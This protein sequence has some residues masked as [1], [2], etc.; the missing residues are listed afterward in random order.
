MPP[1]T[2]PGIHSTESKHGPDLAAAS[3]NIAMH[4]VTGAFAD[5]SHESA[6]AAQLFR[7]ASPVHVLLMASII[8]LSIWIHLIAPPDVRISSALWASSLALCLVDRALIHR[9]HIDAVRAQRIGSWTW[10]VMVVVGV[11]AD[12]GSHV[13]VPVA[14]CAATFRQSS[15]GLIAVIAISFALVNGSH[16][17]DFVHKFALVGLV[18]VLAVPMLAMCGQ[19]ALPAVTCEVGALIVG[20]V[21]AQLAELHLRGSY[22]KERSLEE[23]K[24]RLEDRTEQLQAEK[25]RLQYDLQCRA[26]PLIDDADDRS[27]I[28]RGLRAGPSQ[29][30]QLTGDTDSSEVGGPAPSDSPPPS[31]PAGPPSSTSPDSSEAGGPAPQASL[32]PSQPPT[33]PSNSSGGTTMASPLTSKEVDP[34]HLAA[35]A[36]LNAAFGGS[37]SLAKHQ[38]RPRS[39]PE[40]DILKKGADAGKLARSRYMHEVP[41]LSWADADKQ[42]YASET[43]ANLAARNACAVSQQPEAS[44]QQDLAAAVVMTNMHQADLGGVGRCTALGAGKNGTH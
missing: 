27:A 11:A 10:T 7:L 26:R 24:Q 20:A 43:A 18:G 35:V 44:S 38:K 17:M 39:K 36:A 13:T 37:K 32:P 14:A 15:P 31:L 5:L 22:A 34:R 6:F 21:V 42:F 4:P 29:P 23:D 3:A 30:H 33:G 40:A 41:P 12:F 28:R 25:E 9:L 1:Y 2:I 8:A 16:G 19:T